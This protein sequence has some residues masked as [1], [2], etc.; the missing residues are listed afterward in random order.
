MMG[1][2]FFPTCGSEVVNMKTGE[3]KCLPW[4]MWPGFTTLSFLLH[5]APRLEWGV[6]KSGK[7]ILGKKY[8]TMKLNKVYKLSLWYVQKCAE[9]KSRC[10]WLLFLSFFFLWSPWNL[11]SWVLS[12]TVF[13]RS[14]QQR[15]R[16]YDYTGFFL[17]YCFCSVSK[18]YLSFFI[19][20]II[21]FL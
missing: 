4:R 6:E 9:L 17:Q 5:V 12:C 3:R 2:Y 19:I 18:I 8:F 15:L 1:L 10:F 16:L 13:V 7:L 21:R 20:I 11:V 14:I